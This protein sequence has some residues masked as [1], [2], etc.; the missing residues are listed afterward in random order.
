MADDTTVNF[1]VPTHMSIDGSVAVT[2]PLTNTQLRATDIYTSDYLTRLL[3]GLVEGVVGWSKIGYNGDV[4]AGAEDLWT[5]GGAYVFPTAEMGMEVISSSAEDDPAKA[6]TN[7]GTGIHAVTIYYL[8]DAGAEKSTDV[9]LN[10]TTAVATTATDI[11]RVQNMRTK[12]VGTDGVAAGNIDL[13]HL[14]DTPI[15]TRIATGK[16]R[17]RTLAWTVPAGKTLYVTNIT[18]SVG[19]TSKEKSACFTTLATYDDKAA[20]AVSHFVPYHE[21]VIEDDSFEKALFPFTM[22]PAGTDIKVRV[23]GYVTDCICSGSLRG[24]LVT[25]T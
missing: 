19:G 14:N 10:G 7:P 3:F 12:T 23:E 15:Y 4:D 1:T 11:Y 8:D 17:A 21:F 6:D 16:T 2:G 9:T 5:V 18:V 20:T 24:F 22:L 13:R 25:N